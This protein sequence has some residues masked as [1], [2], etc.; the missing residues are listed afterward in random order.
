M[1]A[2]KGPYRIV[3]RI[4]DVNF[5]LKQ[6]PKAKEEIVH[7]DRLTR[8]CGAI[9]VDFSLLAKRGEAQ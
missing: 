1:L 4:N 9:I 7:I 3:R 8:Y 5:V 6:S 2:N